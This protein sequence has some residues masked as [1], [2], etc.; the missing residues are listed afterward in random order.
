[1]ITIYQLKNINGEPRYT[2]YD[3]WDGRFHGILK[4]LD[5]KTEEEV[6]TRFNTSYFRTAS[7]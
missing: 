2:K 4:G 3:T 7:D 1:M 6:I 5:L